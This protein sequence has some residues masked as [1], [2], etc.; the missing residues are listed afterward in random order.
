[1]QPS[2]IKPEPEPKMLGCL[3]ITSSV[4]VVWMLTE[5]EA[6]CY[7]EISPPLSKKILRSFRCRSL[8]QAQMLRTGMRDLESWEKEGGGA[9]PGVSYLLPQALVRVLSEGNAP[10]TCLLPARVGDTP[11]SPLPLVEG[12]LPPFPDF[13]LPRTAER[14][15]TVFPHDN[16]AQH[17]WVLSGSSCLVG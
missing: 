17:R 14:L 1:M 4:F 16:A 13:E 10:R 2:P 7:Y 6:V 5:C 3:L 9:S 15:P 8:H 12:E 11:S